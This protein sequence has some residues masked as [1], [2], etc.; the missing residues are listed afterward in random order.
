QSG[1]VDMMFGALPS[2][3]QS[4]SQPAASQTTSTGGHLGQT[5][6]TPSANTQPATVS[7]NTAGQTYPVYSGR[8]NT[9]TFIAMGEGLAAGMGDFTLSD[10]MQA[11]SFPAQMARQMQTEFPQPLIQPPGI[12][13]PVGFAKLPVV[14]P[15]AMQT[16]LL[17]GL[18]PA[19]VNNLSVPGFS[20][21]DALKLRPSEPLVHRQDAKQTAANLILG[22]IPIAY[23]EEGRISTQLE[24]AVN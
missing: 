1:V 21:S 24:C 10:A 20:L 15:V 19:P 4:Q 9:S 13:N 16:T 5:Y 6:A 7:A 8:L 18:P 22:V 23:G 11:S 2:N 3:G 17:D 12:C 14:V